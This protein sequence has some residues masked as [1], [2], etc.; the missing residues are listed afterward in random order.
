[1]K[2]NE[3]LAGTFDDFIADKSL[4]NFLTLGMNARINMEEK[5]SKV[6]L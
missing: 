6:F 3:K 2:D 4:N 5:N 1:M